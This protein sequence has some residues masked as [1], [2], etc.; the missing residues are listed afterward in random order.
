M[1]NS[2]P[3]LPD[4]VPIMES[5]PEWAKP[6]HSVEL[7]TIFLGGLLLLAMLAVFYAAAEIALPTVLALLLSLV[8][9]PVLRALEHPL[10]L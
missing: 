5:A 10:P 1:P 6:R 2:D 7:N 3:S 8:F 4:T 9:Q